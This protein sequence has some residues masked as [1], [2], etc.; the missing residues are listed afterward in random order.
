ME[1]GLNKYYHSS[2]VTASISLYN[3]NALVRRLDSQ[4]FDNE[5][6]MSASDM[7]RYMQNIQE[8]KKRIL[9]YV[10][11]QIGKADLISTAEIAAQLKVSEDFIIKTLK[12]FNMQLDI[13]GNG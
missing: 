11:S 5:G 1:I 10:N 4:R 13:I 7:V 2:A 8:K 12:E 6:S 9:E 3:M